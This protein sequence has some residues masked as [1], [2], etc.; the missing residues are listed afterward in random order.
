M[1]AVLVYV[2]Y[3]VYSGKLELSTPHKYIVHHSADRA[4]YFLFLLSG[5]KDPRING[6][7]ASNKGIHYTFFG[8]A[9]ELLWSFLTAR[10]LI[11]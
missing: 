2:V 8:Y 1:C 11:L 5:A 7:R 3:T 9:Y 4:L 6:D 10:L